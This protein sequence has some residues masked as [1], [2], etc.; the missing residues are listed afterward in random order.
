MGSMQQETEKK[1]VVLE[2]INKNLILT[3]INSQSVSQS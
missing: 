2:M 3:L 1:K